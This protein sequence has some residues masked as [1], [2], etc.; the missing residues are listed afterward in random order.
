MPTPS[1]RQLRNNKYLSSDE[2]KFRKQHIATWGAITV[3]LFL[4]LYGMYNNHQ[5]SISQEKRFHARLVENQKI[6]ESISEKVKQLE[7]SRIDY[8]PEINKVSDELNK[9]NEKVDL[10]P[11]KQTVEVKL[12]TETKQNTK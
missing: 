6:V 5:T 3:S 10:V 9:I 8:R 7:I 2:I 1:L 12:L 11:K 4:G